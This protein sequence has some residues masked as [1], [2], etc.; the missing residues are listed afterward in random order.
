MNELQRSFRDFKLNFKYFFIKR[1][2]FILK[3]K[4]HNFY[5]Y[6]SL[7]FLFLCSLNIFIR[8]FCSLRTLKINFIII[9]EILYPSFNDFLNNFKI[10]GVYPLFIKLMKTFRYVFFYLFI[11]L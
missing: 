2:F 5:E 4:N 9:F 11:F 7:F 8:F 1:I 10:N 3:K 6:L